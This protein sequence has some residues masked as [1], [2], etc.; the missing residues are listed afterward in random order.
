MPTAKSRFGSSA[1]GVAGLL[2]TIFAAFKKGKDEEVGEKRFPGG[3]LLKHFLS[4]K[5]F[6]VTSEGNRAPS[7]GYSFR[8]FQTILYN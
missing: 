7:S 2:T 4:Q 3:Y 1:T 5:F 6:T 8:T